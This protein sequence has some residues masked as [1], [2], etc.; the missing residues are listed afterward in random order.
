M[1]APEEDIFSG[2][3]L[4]VVKWGAKWFEEGGG[5]PNLSSSV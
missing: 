5:E 4:L 2:G 3:V 1:G